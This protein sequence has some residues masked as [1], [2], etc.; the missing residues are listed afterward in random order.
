MNDDVM[1]FFEA[2]FNDFLKTEAKSIVDDVHEQSLCG[3]LAQRLNSLKP[4]FGFDGYHV[5][6][7]YNRMKFDVIKKVFREGNTADIR[8]DLIVHVVG[9][10]DNLLALEVKKADRSVEGRRKREDDRQRLMAMT[11]RYDISPGL[12]HVYDYTLGVFIELDRAMRTYVV[13]EF[14]D[15]SSLG[16]KVGNF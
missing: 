5:D 1:R 2:A 8:A 4:G 11:T 15:G 3:Q 9:V 12:E 6:T 7:E 10:R 14:R 16:E 13:E